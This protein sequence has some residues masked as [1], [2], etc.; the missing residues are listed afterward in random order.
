MRSR[1]SVYTDAAP[2]AN[3][4]YSQAVVVDHL[5]YCAGQTPVDPKTGE[6]VSDRFEAQVHQSLANLRAVLQAAGSDLK[7]TVK[8]IVFLKD[9][10]NIAVMDSIYR[11]YF[12]EPFPA[13]STIEVAR[14]PKDA[15]VEI[16]LVALKA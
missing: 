3:G 16:E 14:L 15:Q 6:I 4:S 7:H 11:T 1:S 12:E 2:A 8:T 13:R 9:M 5:I 10:K